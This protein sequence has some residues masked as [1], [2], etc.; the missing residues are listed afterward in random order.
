[1]QRAWRRRAQAPE[2]RR[3]QQH[4]LRPVID[5]LETDVRATNERADMTAAENRRL[6]AKI[7]KLRERLILA[8]G[9]ASIALRGEGNER[10]MSPDPN[11]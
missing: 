1:M 11:H 4:V 7:D 6:W 2:P 5:K 10:A 9:M 3:D 8:E